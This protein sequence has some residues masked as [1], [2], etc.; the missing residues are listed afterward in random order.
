MNSPE[1]FPSLLKIISALSVTLGL[2][3]MVAYL[4][5]KILKKGS[6]AINGKELIKI[7]ST[8]YLGPKSSIMLINVLGNT[9][10]IGVSSSKISLLTEIVDSESLEQ[11]EDLQGKEG[12]SASFSDYLK[13]VL[14]KNG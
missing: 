4:F 1:L 10:L 8:K 11:L 5:K 2:M 9:L 12:K 6:G 13:G 3:I 14:K 7:L